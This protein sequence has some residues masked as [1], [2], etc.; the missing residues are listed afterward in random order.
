MTFKM[1]ATTDE[2]FHTIPY[3]HYCHWDTIPQSGN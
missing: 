1:C 2:A 3:F